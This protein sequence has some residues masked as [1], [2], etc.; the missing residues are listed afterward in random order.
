[1]RMRILSCT[2][3]LAA[4]LSS[5]FSCGSHTKKSP[6]REAIEAILL[7]RAAPAGDVRISTA[8]LSWARAQWW[9]APEVCLVVSVRD[10]ESDLDALLKCHDGRY[11]NVGF[12]TASVDRRPVFL[13]TVSIFPSRHARRMQVV[14]ESGAPTAPHWVALGRD[15][16][17]P[18]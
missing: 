8:N 13:W 2:M 7:G 6:V 1:M 16:E 10:S 17:L 5:G 18:Q 3:L 14:F 11:V 15:P 9:A 4:V 12:S